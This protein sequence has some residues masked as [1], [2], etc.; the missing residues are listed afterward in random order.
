[1]VRTYLA[2]LRSAGLAPRKIIDLRLDSPD[3]R[4]RRVKALL[5]KP[6]ASHLLRRYH[7]FRFASEV[8][9]RLSRIFTQGR[10]VQPQF[11]GAFDY[12]AYAP[13]V[14]RVYASNLRDP[15]LIKILQSQPSRTFLFTG[16]GIVGPALLQIPE[17]RF[18]HIHPG[19]VPDIKGSDGLFWSI[20]VRGRPGASCFYMNAG[21]DT[22]DI[23]ATREFELRRFE[24]DINLYGYDT[25]YGAFLN[26]Y[27]PF[28]R[29]ELLLDVLTGAGET[30]SLNRL[31]AATQDPDAGRT[32]FFMHPKLRNRVIDRLV[33]HHRLRKNG[34]HRE[35]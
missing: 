28:L 24:I 23:I 3:S 27:D 29:S 1:M 19:V 12:K 7:Q 26:F 9:R 15:Y 8:N 34:G 14:Q 20:L 6:L 17:T 5:G 16:G 30:M 33:E 13:D 18:L 4:F 35:L 31:P 32:Y 25:L 2:Y 10:S 22:G 21:I 11:F